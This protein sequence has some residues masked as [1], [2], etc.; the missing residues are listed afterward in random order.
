MNVTL[1]IHVFAE[2]HVLAQ[3]IHREVVFELLHQDGDG[4]VWTDEASGG[5]VA[6]VCGCHGG[7]LVGVSRSSSSVHSAHVLDGV[8][9]EHRG[10]GH[11][12]RA[13][14]HA[15]VGVTAVR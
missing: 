2:E 12:W 10:R 11:G 14:V 5:R 3:V 4:G 9:S 15:A 7:H 8:R 13:H 1:R 6:H